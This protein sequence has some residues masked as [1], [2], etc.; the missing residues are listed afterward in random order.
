MAIIISTL[1]IMAV[2]LGCTNT[3][4]EELIFDLKIENRKLDLEKIEAKQGDTL[5]LNILSNEAGVIHIHGYDYEDM[6]S[7]IDVTKMIFEASITGKF[8]I[9][10]HPGNDHHHGSNDVPIGFLEVY[11]R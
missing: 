1:W 7:K 2:I 4:P 8:S 5:T 10:F 6:V 11:P 9:T 3:G